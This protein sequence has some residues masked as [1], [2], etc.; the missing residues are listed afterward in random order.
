MDHHLKDKKEKIIRTGP[1]PLCRA[2]GRFLRIFFVMLLAVTMLLPAAFS[3]LN[4]A[5]AASSYPAP[6][7][8]KL[9][10]FQ[11]AKG[12]YVAKLS[13]KAKKGQSYQ[14]LRKE[15][16]DSWKMI[17][18]VK[19][20]SS[21]ASYVNNNI[22]AKASYSY[23]VRRVSL[24]N[25]KVNARGKYDKTGIKT[26]K[27]PAMSVDFTNLSAK[28]SWKKVSG[29]KQYLIYRK[30]GENDKYRLLAKVPSEKLSYTDVYA[31]SS[32][33][34][35]MM[36][37]L[38][39]NCFVDLSN[40]PISYYVRA[41]SGVKEG[42]V[43][44]KSYGLYLR[45]GVYHLEPP[46]IVSL[47]DGVLKWGTVTNASGYIILSKAVDGDSWTEV[48]RVTAE[49][50]PSSYQ[51]ASI[52]M[53]D[54]DA[55]Y[56]VQAYAK[57]NGKIEYSEYDTA[58]TLRNS[59]AGSGTNAIFLGDSLTFGSPYFGAQRGNFSYPNRIRQL[60]GISMLNTAVSGSTWHFNPKNERVNIVNGVANMVALGET[61][62]HAYA[63]PRI[64]DN[65]QT[66]EDFDIV[67]LAAGTNDY[68]DEKKTVLGSRETDWEKISDKTTGISF[69]VNA[70]YEQAKTYTGMNYDYN[71][72]TFDGSYNQIY[73][74]IEEASLRRVL[75]GKPPIKVIS[76]GLFYSNRT[77]KSSKIASRNTTK[78]ALGYTLLDYQ[79]EMKA[80]NKIW[81]D[82][83]VLDVLFYDSQKTGIVVNKNCRYR[84]VDNLHFTK[85]TYSLYGDSIADFMLSS[86]VFD[87]M[88]PEGIEELSNSD[89][90][91]ALLEKYVR[92]EVF[93]AGLSDEMKARICE[94]FGIND[95]SEL[96]DPPAVEDE[97]EIIDS[98]DENIGEDA[99]YVDEYE[100]EY[101]YEEGGILTSIDEYES[102]GEY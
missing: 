57:R 35:K 75:E 46:T 67:F 44:K 89:A 101:E 19:A 52:E 90:F 49:P 45:D 97:E 76:I 61:T 21:T 48:A 32:T 59:S 98:D 8:T 77:G 41:Y 16:S 65:T 84:S 27:R 34:T 13:W 82:S 99:A 15:G 87:R 33:D 63:S 91:K 39:R 37:I 26:L 51:T 53:A 92:S 72:R 54:P 60:T 6:E 14:V 20:T 86:G 9:Q 5:Y 30:I 11:T 79:A 4:A 47:T 1:A 80:L 62:E 3:E 66:F 96:I 74:Y 29:A 55:Y 23:T 58:F 36:A 28:I 73:K 56:A 102:E 88:S 18:S 85:Y 10:C 2:S 42:K 93:V 25:G 17:A 70:G 40:D 7:L 78:N 69:T 38:K 71:I 22:S 81:A 83:P 24:K 50:V 100:D 31:D 94:L 43:T 68:A 12:V 64:G 95:I